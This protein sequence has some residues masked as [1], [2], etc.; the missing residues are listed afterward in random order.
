MVGGTVFNLVGHR[1]FT[2]VVCME[3][4]MCMEVRFENN[5]A[6]Q[7]NT[8]EC[9]SEYSCVGIAILVFFNH[10]AWQ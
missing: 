4:E 5:M 10:L 1:M 6:A 9:A 3:F 8:V 2:Q 7:L